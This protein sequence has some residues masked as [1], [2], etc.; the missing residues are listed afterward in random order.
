MANTDIVA[1]LNSKQLDNSNGG[2][3]IN[4]QPFVDPAFY[5]PGLTDAQRWRIVGAEPINKL[6]RRM[7]QREV[8]SLNFSITAKEKGHEDA[9]AYYNDLY[10]DFRLLVGKLLKSVCELPQGGALEVG[11]IKPGIFGEGDRGT[12]AFVKFIDAGTLHPTIHKDYP[13]LQVN[14][15]NTL[16]RVPFKDEEILRFVAFPY[17]EFD[18][19]WWQ[20]SPTMA[21]FMAI[22]ALS[23]I[24]IYYLKQLHDTPVVG[25]L[26]L[27]DFNEDNARKWATSFREMIEG[28]DPIKIPVLYEHSAQA[29]WIPMGRNPAELSIPQQFKQFSEI[30]L[31]NYGLSLADL[32][33]FEQGDS[34]AGGA[35]SRK[36]TMQSGISF[37]AE[38][39]KDGFQSLLPPYLIFGYTDPDVEEERTKAMVRSTNARTIQTLN[40]LPVRLK[41]EQAIKD[42][43]IDLDI[44]PAEIEKEVQE[45][46]GMQAGM[47]GITK[48]TPGQLT[49]GEGTPV[50]ELET[51]A[52]E[53]AST[54][55]VIY[56][57]KKSETEEEDNLSIP[58]L[59]EKAV[60]YF[61][62]E[63]GDPKSKYGKKKELAAAKLD[64]LLND[65]FH[66]VG[67]NI[68]KEFVSSILDAVYTQFPKLA[69][70]VSTAPMESKADFID[71][72]PLV[73]IN[74]ADEENP[75]EDSAENDESDDYTTEPVETTEEVKGR[76]GA[77]LESIFG[78]IYVS[79]ISINNETIVELLIAIFKLSYEDGM[80]ATSEIVQNNLYGRG[81]VAAP[82]IILDYNV[83]DTTVIDLLKL[84]AADMVKNVDNGTKYYLKQ[85][86][87]EGVMQ[88]WSVDQITEAIQKDIFG[89]SAEEASK[90]NEI[91]IRS[92]V[93]TEINR[94]D[95]AGRLEEMKRIGLKLK[96]WIT[97]L[98]DVCTLCLR[99]E[100]QGSVPL[101]F[102]YEDVFGETLHPPGHPSTCHCG[103]GADEKELDALGTAVEY[104]TGA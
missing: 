94:A 36:I 83:I 8:A 101:D 74:K 9:V 30:I 73:Y 76:L 41:I 98:V 102:M 45:T 56:A 37:Y 95:S 2:M 4:R 17:D 97:R 38:L 52:R 82:Y 57:K 46:Q 3:Y 59:V 24:Y 89:L 21:S 86:I 72:L 66:E 93:T 26:D 69:L 58:Q 20:E 87:I 11:W 6:A 75:D 60:Q 54:G 61:K 90:L 33:L 99:N 40:F 64:K 14:P 25:I 100:A 44:D 23:R 22:E 80:L 43:V 39:V 84:Y 55:T 1:Q 10:K 31:S 27:M 85:L 13:I 47:Q 19:E 50:N 29:H 7:I 103:L 49:K 42:G 35:V 48:P 79:R 63:Y 15:Y 28:I 96:R 88:G 78:P 104:W 65:R 53:N 81:I 91:R 5:R 34:K 62:E 77:L 51:N 68:T 70:K 32:R 92:I 67:K 16:Q 12:P 18:K 71:E